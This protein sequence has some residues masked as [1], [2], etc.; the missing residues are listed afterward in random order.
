MEVIFLKPFAIEVITFSH[1]YISYDNILA[2]IKNNANTT[3]VVVP[4][5]VAV[6]EVVKQQRQQ[7]QQQLL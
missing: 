5:A 4:A 1:I 6:A 7:P 3:T 2:N